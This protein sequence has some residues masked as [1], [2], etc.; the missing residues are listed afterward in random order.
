MPRKTSCHW[1]CTKLS[2]HLSG[3]QQ[4]P[5]LEMFNT[6]LEESLEEYTTGNNLL[7]AE[8]W[9]ECCKRDFLSLMFTF[10]DS[11]LCFS[12]ITCK[13]K[14]IKVICFSTAYLISRVQCIWCTLASFNSTSR[15]SSCTLPHILVFFSKKGKILTAL[16]EYSLLWSLLS[17]FPCKTQR[18]NP[19]KHPRFGF[20]LGEGENDVRS[21]KGEVNQRSINK[22]FRT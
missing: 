22:I 14:S 6:K 1:N 8:R 17:M 7:L 20:G 16:G 10:Y 2:F 15:F 19:S 21:L 13:E 11:Y 4:C 18:K 9:T 3:E 5:S 12:F